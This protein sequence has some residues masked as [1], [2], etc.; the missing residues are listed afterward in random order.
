MIADEELTG[1][2]AERAG[3]EGK[4]PRSVERPVRSVRSD[5]RHEAAVEVVLVDGAAGRPVLLSIGDEHVTPENL[6]V[7]G[8][9][10]RG[11]VWIREGARAERSRREVRVEDVDGALAK[12]RGVEQGRGAGAGHRQSPVVGAGRR[13]LHGDGRKGAFTIGSLEAAGGIHGGTPAYD[14]S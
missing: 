13:R 8:S 10:A 3:G 6:D 11:K 1:Q 4:S 9:E 12:V 2:A 7:E 5:A 14:R